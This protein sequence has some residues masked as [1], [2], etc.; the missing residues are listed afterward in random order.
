MSRLDDIDLQSKTEVLLEALPY[1]QRFGGSVFVVKIGG[2]FLEEPGATERV[3]ID[4]AF[5]STVGIHV[6]LVHGGGK[7]IS[8]AME[9]AAIEPVFSNG[10]RVTDAATVGLVE[11]TLNG[12]INQGIVD[13]LETIG[14]AGVGVFGQSVFSCEK[15]CHDSAGNP[16]DLGFVGKINSVTTTE[17]ETLLKA[18]KLPVVSPVGIDDTGHFYN[19][20]ADVAASHLAIA[21]SARRL[22]YLC[23]VPGLMKDPSDPAT[24]ISTLRMGEVQSLKDS[25]VIGSGMMP[26]VDS[27]QRAILGGVHRTHFIDGKLP[28]SLLLEI[29][30][31]KGIGTEIVQD[32]PSSEA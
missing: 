25:G 3:A 16:V 30:T 13:K 12:V 23:D 15:L 11:K 27:A 14:A 24:L 32:D 21:L 20:N 31:D 22:V 1:F 18:G 28:H 9:E 29:F 5:L 7:A 26:K 6:V 4:V 19:I 2:S 17:V 8:R 10:M